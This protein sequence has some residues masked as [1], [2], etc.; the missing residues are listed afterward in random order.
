MLRPL[1]AV[2]EGNRVEDGPNT[3]IPHFCSCSS[4]A[5]PLA[6]HAVKQA[7]GIEATSLVRQFC[8]DGVVLCRGI[9]SATARYDHTAVAG[10]DDKVRLG[11]GASAWKR[12]G[13]DALARRCMCSCAG[14]CGC[15]GT[16]ALMLVAK[17]VVAACILI[18]QSCCGGHGGGSLIHQSYIRSG[19]GVQ[20]DSSIKRWRS[21]RRQFGSSVMLSQWWRCAV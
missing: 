10:D 4:D 16:A 11:A 8:S 7:P 17:A 15:A 9:A 18:H 6:R 14:W 5:A 13:V 19:G 2:S 3:A 12:V 1:Y 21:W 20:F